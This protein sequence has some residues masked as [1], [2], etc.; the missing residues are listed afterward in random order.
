[1]RTLVVV[2]EHPY[3]GRRRTVGTEYEA[4]DFDAALLVKSGQ[5]RYKDGP[6]DAHTVQT[7]HTRELVAPGSGNRARRAKRLAA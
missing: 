2:T 7:Y 1:M 6:P 3:E 4:T 5:A